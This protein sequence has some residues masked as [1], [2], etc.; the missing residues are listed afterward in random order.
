MLRSYRFREEREAEWRKLEALLQRAEGRG[1]GALS[2]QDMLDLPRLY[3]AAVSSLSVA[4]AISLDRNVTAYL[5]ALCARAY[6]FVYGN[7]SRLSE[8]LAD[9]F[10]HDWPAAVA[11][12]SR[13]MAFS[14]LCFFGA[15]LIAFIAFMQDPETFWLFHDRSWFDGRNPDATTEFLR[16]TLYNNESED[17]QEAL[18]NFASKLF[19]NNAGIAILAFALGFGFGIPTAL[20]LIY[21]GLAIG[22]FYALFWSRGLGFE[23]TGWLMIHGVTELLAIVVAGAGGF[24]VGMAVAFPGRRTRIRAARDHGQRA[25]HLVMGAVVMLFI[26]ALLE[27]FGRELINSDAV[28]YAI[29]IATAVFWAVYFSPG[30]RRRGAAP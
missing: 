20:L 4:R 27:S 11:A 22:S 29:A 28:R 24:V 21:N 30:R 12:S 17:L 19:S 5:E 7:R 9:F 3:R 18:I 14:A 13:A 10:Q 6:F 15:A 2:P 23:L 26:A 16:S 25:G 8:K 1:I